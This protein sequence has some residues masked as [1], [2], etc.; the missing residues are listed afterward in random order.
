MPAHSLIIPAIILTAYPL[1]EPDVDTLR[2]IL[3]AREESVRT[4]QADLT[5]VSKPGSQRA[6]MAAERLRFIDWIEANNPEI[7]AEATRNRPRVEAAGR[8]QATST[9]F[10]R[11]FAEPSGKLRIEVYLGFEGSQPKSSTASNVRVFTGEEW[12]SYVAGMDRKTGEKLAHLTVQQ[13]EREN[14]RWHDIAIGAGVHCDE[15]FEMDA[16]KFTL[17]RRARAANVLHWS[18]LLT[19]VPREQSRAETSVPPGGTNPSPSLILET[20]PFRDRGKGVRRWQLWFDEEHAY[21]LAACVESVLR[22]VGGGV[23]DFVPDHIVEWDDPVEIGSFTVSQKCTLRFH[24]IFSTVV[25]GTRSSDDWP[26]R[27]FE[28]LRFDY[29]L[30]NIK[31]NEPLDAANRRGICTSRGTPARNCTKR[32]WPTGRA[33]QRRK[34]KRI[35]RF[36][37]GSSSTRSMPCSCWLS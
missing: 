19:Q 16:M 9:H 36:A 22:P 29:T 23:W 8:S 25:E 18:E 1:T 20:K 5:V 15:L 27:A 35:G 28:G 37:G 32:R 2:S 21:R 33:G 13:S 24:D 10:Y 11:Y 14:L 17:S 4:F 30:A 3:R 31:V 34:W 12:K 26:Y 7:A 6:E